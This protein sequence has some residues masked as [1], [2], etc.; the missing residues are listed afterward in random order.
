MAHFLNGVSILGE[1]FLEWVANLESRAA[2]THPK[3]TQGAPLGPWDWN[4]K[5]VDLGEVS[6]SG[7]LKMQY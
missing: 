5:S 6:T 4:R 2:H 1:I 3:N 7:R